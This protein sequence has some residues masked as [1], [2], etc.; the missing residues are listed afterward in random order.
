MNSII[1]P[2]TL[3]DIKLKELCWKL[4]R[5]IW[6]HV[7]GGGQTDE[8]STS[9]AREESAKLI[10]EYFGTV[11]EARNDEM[12]RWKKTIDAQRTTLS[13]QYEC[14][15]RALYHDGWI[16]EKDEVKP[17]PKAGAPSW[18]KQTISLLKLE[19]EPN[20]PPRKKE[21]D[22]DINYDFHEGR[23]ENNELL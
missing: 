17:F 4:D 3:M 23:G 16:N 1:F 6:A 8:W 9:K 13:Q 18:V 22:V 15:I 20:L 2:L 11:E 7:P 19:S 10:T 14:L 12:N 21:I 5:E